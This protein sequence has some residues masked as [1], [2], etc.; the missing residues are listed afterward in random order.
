MRGYTVTLSLFV[1]ALICYVLSHELGAIAFAA[2]GLGV[3]S[4]FWIRLLA[5]RHHATNEQH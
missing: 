5:H 4:L 1:A 2:I 3:E